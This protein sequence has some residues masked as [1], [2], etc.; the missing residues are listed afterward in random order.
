MDG[1]TYHG[2]GRALIWDM[3]RFVGSDLVVEIFEALDDSGLVVVAPK[4][5]G[6]NELLVLTERAQRFWFFSCVRNTE[7]MAEGIDAPALPLPLGRGGSW[8]RGGWE[9]AA[10]TEASEAFCTLALRA[11]C[12]VCANE[13]GAN[14]ARLTIDEVCGD[15]RMLREALESRCTAFMAV[16]DLAGRQVYILG[17]R[18]WF[19]LDDI[20]SS[21]TPASMYRTGTKGRYSGK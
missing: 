11:N 15:L 16:S 3:W 12:R 14:E 1:E 8:Y 6:V 5:T 2:V 10:S 7:R 18:S 21:M 9:A 17:V 20:R 19:V 13:D 4:H